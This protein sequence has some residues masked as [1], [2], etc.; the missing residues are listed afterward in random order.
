MTTGTVCCIINIEIGCDKSVRKGDNM[1]LFKRIAAAFLA[2]V[3]AAGLAFVSGCGEGRS[4]LLRGAS[5]I[6]ALTSGEAESAEFASVS[7]SAEAFAAKFAEAVYTECDDGKNIALSP[8]SVYAALALASECA[9]GE[10]RGQML[11]ALGTTYDTLSEGFGYLYRSL[12]REFDT[13]KVAFGNSV[14]VDEAAVMNDDCLDA[15]A[16]KYFCDSYSADFV[17]DNKNANKAVRHFIKESTN[18]LIDTDPELPAE[19]YFALLNV[20][21]LKD[22]WTITDDLEFTDEEMTFTSSGGEERRERFLRALYEQGRAYETET[23]TTFYSET[24]A[25]Y[26]LS[27]ILPNGGYTAREVFTAENIAEVTALSDYSAFDKETETAYYTRCIFPAF[28]A[29]YDGEIADVLESAFGISYLFD[30]HKCDITRA[31]SEENM[32]KGRAHCASVRHVTRLNV[33]ETG[34]EGAAV[35]QMAYAGTSAPPQEEV[36]RDFVVDR[37][38]GFVLTAPNGTTLF[39]GV[40]NGL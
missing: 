18:G 36:Y 16:Q 27:F 28:E 12:V 4:T 22:Q 13:G 37:A 7:E 29:S 38:F 10:T 15:L 39:S 17:N 11:S 9:A 23:Y 21:Y 34:I 30:E 2:V 6:T 19:T 40:V 5:E 25:G 35:T 31:I 33:D 14:W 8:V 20:L 1:K 26:K 24:H 3:A 32:T